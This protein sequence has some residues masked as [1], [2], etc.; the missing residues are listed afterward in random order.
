MNKNTHGEIKVQRIFFRDK[1]MKHKWLKK[2][3][4]KHYS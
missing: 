4:R 2:L 3:S 1:Y